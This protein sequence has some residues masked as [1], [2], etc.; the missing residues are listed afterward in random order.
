MHSGVDA[1]E[2]HLKTKKE[3]EKCTVCPYEHSWCVAREENVLL[4]WIYFQAFRGGERKAVKGFGKL[5]ADLGPEANSSLKSPKT[6]S[7]SYN[8]FE[9]SSVA[10][11]WHKNLLFQQWRELPR[12]GVNLQLT[13]SICMYN[14][15]FISSYS[16]QFHALNSV[17]G[18]TKPR[19]NAEFSGCRLSV[20]KFYVRARI[21]QQH[22]MV[23]YALKLSW[24]DL[25]SV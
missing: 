25:I 19:R 7:A 5:I 16:S 23:L 22:A 20:H 6:Y 2:S 18:C 13:H 21:R 8:S 11:W 3:L 12:R 9:N 4:A 15:E 14:M 1:H 17:P 10:L 24:V